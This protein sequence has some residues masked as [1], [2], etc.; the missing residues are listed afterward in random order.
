MRVWIKGHISAA[1]PARFTTNEHS[2]RL[3]DAE[4]AGLATAFRVRLCA[5]AVIAVWLL[6]STAWPRN[7]YYLAVSL[8]FLA[9]SY[10]PYAMRHHRAAWPIKLV[11][12]VV[13]VA[14]IT[15]T[16]LLPPFGDFALDW[17]V[18]TRTRGAEYLYVILLLA[19]SA[20]TY[21]PILVMWTG[22]VIVA[23]WSFGIGTIYSFADTARLA[24]GRKLT[25]TEALD[26][27]LSPN[28][29]SISQ[30]IIQVVTTV[31]FT[32]ILAIAVLRSRNT[33]IAQIKESAARESLALYVSP[34]LAQAMS[35]ETASDFGV[36]SMRKVAVMFV[37]IVGFTQMSEGRS[38]ERALA[39]LRSFQERGCSVIFKYNGTLDKFLGDGFMATFGGVDPKS[40][41][42][43]LA[44]T[45][46]FDLLDTF[47]EWNT[48]RAARDAEPVHVS[49]GLHFGDVIVGDV[50]TSE[51]KEFTVIG[52]VV[53]VASR[54]ER[55]TREMAGMLLVSDSCLEAAGG[56]PSGR[57]FSQSLTVDIKGRHGSV[58]AHLA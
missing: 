44:V 55:A 19:E 39:L 18:Q 33:L 25:E 47:A 13:D 16:I 8:A 31:L 26:W 53:N 17:P 15:S 11:C 12:T 58:D 4:I 35:D 41:A 48:K 7:M 22:S 14:L 36:P 46:A 56:V 29:V 24:E 28:F 23:V 20:L 45:C 30:A 43:E 37:D 21:S 3:Y 32:L 38:P 57:S 51:R 50:G 34:D 52:D 5:V 49:I 54:L 27:Y 40:D 2:R 6:V 10:I 9:L 1:L 42:A